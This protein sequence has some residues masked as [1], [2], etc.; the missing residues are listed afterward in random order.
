MQHMVKIIGSVA[1]ER[2]QMESQAKRT[3]EPDP[4][5]FRRVREAMQ[6]QGYR[7][8][9]PITETPEIVQL[10]KQNPLAIT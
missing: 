6:A 1:N 10:K 8:S 5:L 2:W 7:L 9:I 4:V 3:W